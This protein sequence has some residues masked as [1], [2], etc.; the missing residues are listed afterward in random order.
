VRVLMREKAAKR[1]LFLLVA[2]IVLLIHDLNLYTVL[3]FTLS[4]ILLSLEAINTAIE[5][6]CN[7]HTLEFDE[8]IRAIK[9]VAAT[10]IFIIP[11]LQLALL[12]I[13]YAE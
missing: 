3:I 6:L 5:L 9:D 2:S 10:A 11:C 12:A 8:R 13:W 1:E 7:L 4:C